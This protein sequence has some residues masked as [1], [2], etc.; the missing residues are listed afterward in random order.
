VSLLYWLGAAT[1]MTSQGRRSAFVFASDAPRYLGVEY[2]K[3]LLLWAPEGLG[4]S[5]FIY[6]ISV[7]TLALNCDKWR[8]HLVSGEPAMRGG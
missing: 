3:T 4:T 8:N 7:L 5:L 1:V 2:N 6:G